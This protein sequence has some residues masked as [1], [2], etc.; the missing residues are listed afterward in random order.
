M[1]IKIKNCNPYVKITVEEKNNDDTKV[2]A[3]TVIQNTDSPNWVDEE[4]P[5]GYIIDLGSF[6]K[7]TE[8]YITFEVLS[9]SYS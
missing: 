7:E 6:F 1:N 2:Y 4:Y 8:V 5:S 3:S 9:K